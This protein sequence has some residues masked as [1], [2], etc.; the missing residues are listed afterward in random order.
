MGFN[1]QRMLPMIMLAAETASVVSKVM[2]KKATVT[3]EEVDSLVNNITSTLNNEAKSIS[4]GIVNYSDARMCQ[5]SDAVAGKSI[6]DV[7]Q[8]GANNTVINGSINTKS[9]ISSEGGL[10]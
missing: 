8:Q 10:L 2:S 1:I 7:N 5:T 3:V 6:S 9:E 4:Q